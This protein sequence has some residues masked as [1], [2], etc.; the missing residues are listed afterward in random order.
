[1]SENGKCSLSKSEND[2]KNIFPLKKGFTSQNI[3]VGTWKAVL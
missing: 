2:N 3:D 1:M